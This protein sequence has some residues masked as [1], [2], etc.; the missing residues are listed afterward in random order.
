MWRIARRTGAMWLLL[1]A[2][3]CSAAQ[4]G[5]RSPDDESAEGGSADYEGDDGD[6]REGGGEAETAGPDCSDGTCFVCGEGMCPKGFYGDEQAEGGP[7]C[8]WLPDCAE[9]ATCDCVKGALG[10]GCSCEEYGDGGSHVTC[11]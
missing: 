10:S 1:S 11:G 5:A 3:A 6:Y 8:S 9:D 4:S 7:A 2:A